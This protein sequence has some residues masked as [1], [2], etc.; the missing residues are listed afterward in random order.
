VMVSGS[1]PRRRFAPGV[2]AELKTMGIRYR[3]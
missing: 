2:K 3:I 1:G